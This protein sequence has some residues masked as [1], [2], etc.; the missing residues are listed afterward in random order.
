MISIHSVSLSLLVRESLNKGTSSLTTAL[1][2]MSTGY[3]VNRAKDDAANLQISQGLTTGIN[4][5][6]VLKNGASTAL[7]MLNTTEGILN[8]MSN[9]ILRIRD[10][11]LQKMNGVYDENALAAMNKEIQAQVDNIV[12]LSQKAEFNGKK[13]LDGS[14]KDMLVPLYDDGNSGLASIDL[15]ALFKE[16]DFIDVLTGKEDLYFIDAKAGEKYYADFDGK[17]FEITSDTDQQVIYKYDSATGDIEFVDCEGVNYVELGSYKNDYI[18]LGSGEQ[19]LQ[20]EANKSYY[21]KH[22]NKVFEFKNTNAISQI[23]VFKDDGA[24]GLELVNGDGVTKTE[25]YDLDTY[26]SISSGNSLELAA[27]STQHIIFNKKLYEITSTKNQTLIFNNQNN[28]FNIIAGGD[29]VT[30]T[31]LGNMK[32]GVTTG[33]ASYVELNA[34]ETKYYEHNGNIYKLSNNSSTKQNYIIDA[35]NNV[36]DSNGNVVSSQV[37]TVSLVDFSAYTNLQSM[38]VIAGNNYYLKNGDGSVTKITANQTGLIYFDKTT[39]GY[40]K[41]KGASVT[42]SNAGQFEDVS[43]DSSNQ[44]TLSVST[45]ETKHISIGDEIYTITNDTGSDYTKVFSYDALTKSITEVLSG[46]ITPLTR[47]EALAQGY[48]LIYTADELQNMDVSLSPD[49]SAPAN[50]KFI[51]MNDIDLSGINWN[52]FYIDDWQGYDSHV[53][54]LNGNGYQIKNLS[55]NGSEEAGLFGHIGQFVALT[56]K[57]LGIVDADIESSNYAGAFIGYAWGEGGD[58]NLINTYSTGSIVSSRFAGGLV[59]IS[60]DGNVGIENSYSSAVVKGSIAGGLLGYSMYGDVISNSYFDGTVIADNCAGGIVGSDD[61]SKISYCLVSGNVTATNGVAGGMV[62]SSSDGTNVKNSIVTGAVSGTTDV[63]GIV[64][65]AEDYDL[66]FTNVIVTG[67]VSGGSNSHAIVGSKDSITSYIFTDVY[68]DI[69]KTGQSSGFPSD[70]TA[71]MTNV[72]GLSSAEADEKKKSILGSWDSGIWDLSSDTPRL[73]ALTP[74]S[75]AIKADFL[76]DIT[77]STSEIAEQHRYLENFSGTAY[78][79]SGEDIYEIKNNGATQDVLLDYDIATGAISAVNAPDIEI[80]KVDKASFN[81]LNNTNF[82]TIMNAGETMYMDFTINGVK[83]VYKVTN[84]STEKQ[85]VIFEKT[86]NVSIKSGDNILIEEYTDMVNATSVSSDSFYIDFAGETKK[87]IYI[88]GHFYEITN[89][90]GTNALFRMNGDEIVQYAGSTT[91]HTTKSE[92]TGRTTTSN[93]YSIELDANETRYIKIGDSAFELK[94]STG[95]KQT[96]IFT[97]NGNSLDGLNP[98]I[99]ANRLSLT[100]APMSQMLIIADFS[101]DDISKRRSELGAYA[102]AIESSINRNTN[103][104]ENY[105][106]AKSTIM[107]ADMAEESCK[108]VQSQILQRISSSLLS[109][110]DAMK[111]DILLRLIS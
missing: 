6:K 21:I 7:D 60:E 78:L 88:N 103:V 35:N 68:W 41:F 9:S 64:G 61:D 80:K 12:Q 107:D 66:Y 47:E 56:I 39:T 15:T 33:L 97:I 32:A 82:S 26:S 58:V 95:V 29:G 70:S 37:S 17:V 75:A 20:M 16:L 90:N 104:E 34:N 28:N 3:K 100:N 89:T 50:R 98:N 40:D 11:T 36:K 59:G 5:A 45:G 55:Y 54:E 71:I 31:A 14:I 101:L 86:N 51:L 22:N 111:S 92:S 69:D 96:Q 30:V 93:Q 102:N 99:T 25:L 19:Y 94:N 85:S 27:G 65:F 23:A 79:K 106:A 72:N 77:S 84:N 46:S 38:A 13:L 44:F 87:N 105:T 18:S 62:G 83:R 43:L 91:T 10:L 109:Q 81:S 110:V 42:L 74:L 4:S 108:F 57:N 73:R 76:G 1:E 2:R 67:S 63:G 52:P 24:G 53:I 48:T 8:S 49:E